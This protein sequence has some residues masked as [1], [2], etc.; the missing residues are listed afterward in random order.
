[1][2]F[3]ESS[4]N[5]WFWDRRNSFF[6]FLR[7]KNPWFQAVQ[8]KRSRLAA[9][10]SSSCRCRISGNCKN[11]QKQQ[12]AVHEKKE[13]RPE[14]R[15]EGWE[16]RILEKTDQNWAD[17]QKIENIPHSS[18]K[19]SQ[20]KKKIQPQVQSYRCLLQSY[21]KIS[22]TGLMQEVYR[23]CSGSWCL[24]PAAQP[25]FS[26]CR[27]TFGRS[28][29]VCWFDKRLPDRWRYDIRQVS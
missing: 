22:M 21:S 7:R 16:Q 26:R 23:R 12:N 13:L 6:W 20:Q 28:S 15:G 27:S 19:I 18:G 1:M 29:E 2:L 17:I 25:S 4:D 8:G 3:S 24:H 14:R 9:A 10:C 11:S 5:C